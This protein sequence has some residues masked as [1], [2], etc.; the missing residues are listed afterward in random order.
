MFYR[1]NNRPEAAK[2]RKRLLLVEDNKSMLSLLTN[3][4]SNEFEVQS[5]TC[6]NE[7]I[8]WIADGT[9]RVDVI[10]S[11]VN[12]DNSTG[13][14]LAKHLET[15]QVSGHIPLI[16]LSGMDKGYMEKISGG[17]SYA[18]YINKPFNPGSLIDQIK[19]VTEPVYQL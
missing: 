16:F 11:D 8:E 17:F 3:I 13:I 14:D 5:F 12:L 9:N 18:A 6:A 10:V 2:N 4:L 19:E 7:A 15:C 1:H